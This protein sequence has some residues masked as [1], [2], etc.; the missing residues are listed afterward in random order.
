[1]VMVNS[2][3]CT[4][5]KAAKRRNLVSVGWLQMD[6]A[7]RGCE[8]DGQPPA[9]HVRTVDPTAA[10]RAHISCSLALGRSMCGELEF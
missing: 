3:T 5:T 7:V 4:G 8:V 6:A 2:K 9:V 1:M 10:V